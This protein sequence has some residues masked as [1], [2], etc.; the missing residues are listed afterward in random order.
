MD[1]I[2]IRNLR[3]LED[4]GMVDLK[5]ITLLL[6]ANSSGKST[7]LRTI[8]LFKQSINAKTIG[9]LLWYGNEVDFGAYDTALRMGESQMEFSFFWKELTAIPYTSYAYKGTMR[10]ISVSLTL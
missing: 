5:P 9:P 1:G 7:F 8:P 4:T 6:G 10:D 3:C 2:R